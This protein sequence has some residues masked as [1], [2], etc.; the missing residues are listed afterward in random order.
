MNTSER[1]LEI[2]KAFRDQVQKDKRIRNAYLLVESAKHGIKLNIAA[3]KTGAVLA[4]PAQCHHM[5]SVGKLF[6]ATLIS[7][8]YEQGKLV[9]EDPIARYLDAELMNGL[10]LY[11]GGDYS[12][13]ITVRQLLMQSSGLNDVFYHL[14][15]KLI[16]EPSFQISTREAV[17]WGKENLKPVARPGKRHFYTDTNYYLLGMII[18]SISGKP[19]YELMHEYIFEPLRMDHAFMHGFTKPK[20]ETGLPDSGIF[21]RD[22]DFRSIPGIHHIDHAGGSVIAPLE[23]F[24]SFFKAL[25][26]GRII[27][28]KTLERMISDDI[29]MGFPTLGF[30]YGYSIWKFKEIPILVPKNYFCWGCVGVTGAFMFFHPDTESYIIGTFNDYAYRGKALEFMAKKIVRTLLRTT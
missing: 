16:T 18:E 5:A 6:T 4:D 9:F 19:F 15:K 22:R 14:W 21:A 13:E 7:I 17:V 10:H 30:N 3:G 20:L 1:Q 11:K 2:E 23:E 25:N 8:L 28:K 24:L 26:E 29:Y 27:S 12:S